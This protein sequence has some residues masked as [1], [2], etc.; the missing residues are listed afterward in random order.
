MWCNLFVFMTQDNAQY[1]TTV[2]YGIS[3]NVNSLL[4]VDSPLSDLLS[5]PF[6][7]KYTYCLII[8]ILHKHLVNS[9][10]PN[11]NECIY[12]LLTFK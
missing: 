11:I 2:L 10:I 1:L 8:D 3:D 5:D 7:D 6:V 4:S 12:S 9:V